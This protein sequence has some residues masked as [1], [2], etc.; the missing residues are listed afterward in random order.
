MQEVMQT[1]D[2]VLGNGSQQKGL[3]NEQVI[4][5]LKEALSVGTGNS[6]NSASASDGFYKN[7]KIFLP[8]P[9][10]AIKVKDKLES[11]GFKEPVDKFV[12]TLNRAA[13]EA[14]KEA[15]P[16][17]LNAITSMTIADGFN[18][19]KGADNAATKYLQDKTSD[20]LYTTFKPKVKGAI[21]KVQLTKYW[22]PVI[23]KY[24]AVT[25]L[26]G[27]DKVNP[28]LEDYVTRRAMS[29]LFTLIADE[30]LKI[31]KDPVARV[32]DILKTVFSTLDK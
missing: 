30:E 2:T 21:E 13:E 26:T 6:T 20:A 7:T 27:G 28:D 9:P 5:G 18:I 29:G 24:N 16:I 11:I 3:T 8:F 12:L 1:T 10:D 19:L 17:F 15:K 14:T 23:N 32:T 22:E 4:Q 31:R 25:A